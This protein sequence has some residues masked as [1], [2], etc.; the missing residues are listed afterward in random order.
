MTARRAP[1]GTPRSNGYR[2]P[3]EWSAHAGTWI[4]WPHRPDDWPGRFDA[5]PFAF[6]EIVR[7]LA[8]HEPVRIVVGS[9]SAEA[10]ARALIESGGVDPATVRFFRWPTDRSWVRDSGPIFVRTPGA[11]GAPPAVAVTDWKFNAWAKYDD[12][13]RDDRLPSRVARE[14]G[15]PAWRPVFGEQRVV[16]EGGAIDVNGAG[17]LLATEEC[18]LSDVQARNPGLDQEALERVFSEY[19]GVDR[20][21]WLGRGIVGDDTHGHVDDVARFVGPRTIVAAREADPDDP[22]H[23]IL[24]ENLTRLH[25]ARDA[26]G[27]PFEVVELPMPRPLAYSGQ[28]VPASYLNFYIANGVVLVPTF[29]DP[30]DRLA[31]AILEHQFP[32]RTVVGLHSGDLIWGLGS[33]HCLTQQELSATA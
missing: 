12:W 32:G 11:N 31:L 26:E 15:L 25:D 21:V 33:V 5:I 1:R 29:N 10:R 4:A 16:L 17:T 13:E 19:L 14:L 2:M 8:P 22:N 9:A 28:R 6:A 24:E 3:A 30:A 18:L 27:Q 20:V 23:R 7:H